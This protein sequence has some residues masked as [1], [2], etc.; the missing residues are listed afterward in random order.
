MPNW[1]S[2]CFE[3]PFKVYMC[4]ASTEC[5]EDRVPASDIYDECMK[6]YI[7]VENLD[8]NL[9]FCK[10][11]DSG[12]DDENDPTIK[13]LAVV[14]CQLKWRGEDGPVT[15]YLCVKLDFALEQLSRNEHDCIRLCDDPSPYL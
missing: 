13:T 15:G 14:R 4:E 10:P 1:D 11:G 3:P 2:S 8:H 5:G 9:P 7:L 6:K 12:A